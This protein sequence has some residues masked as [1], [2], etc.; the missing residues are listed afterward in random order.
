MQN[1][2][3]IAAILLIPLMLL[4]SFGF[5]L[6][7]HICRGEIKSVGLFS[8]EPCEMEAQMNSEKDISDLPP[9]QQRL[10]KKNQSNGQK[11]GFN[12]GQ[13]CHNEQMNFES[14]SE[15]QLSKTPTLSQFKAVIV[16]TAIDLQ[17]FNAPITP[18][19][20]EH[21]VP[22]LRPDNLHILHQVFII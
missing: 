3:K 15:M 10:I 5:S 14:S 11:N 21:Y 9:C 4:S 18:E 6:D 20:Y 13:C 16:Y 7:V 2:R 17:L 8:A 22:P 12:N 1:T 19:L